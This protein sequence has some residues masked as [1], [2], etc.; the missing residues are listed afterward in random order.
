MH[1]PMLPLSMLS[2]GDRGEIC[3]VLCDS[4]HSRRLQELGFRP[5]VEIEIVQAGSPCIVRMGESKVCFRDDDLS[6]ILVRVNS[7]V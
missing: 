7:S 1:A 2:S 6:S 5:G 3:S 4:R